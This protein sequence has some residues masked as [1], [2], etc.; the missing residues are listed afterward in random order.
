MPS[1]CAHCWAHSALRLMNLNRPGLAGPEA[2]EAA[3]RKLRRDATLC[4]RDAP[5]PSRLEVL[6][7]KQC[8]AFVLWLLR[9]SAHAFLG[10]HRR[11]GLSQPIPETTAHILNCYQVN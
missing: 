5:E 7:R 8:P 11:C 3:C 2:N 6:V 1:W 4:Q 9:P 10:R